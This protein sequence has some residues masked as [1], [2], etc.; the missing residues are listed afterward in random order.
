[1]GIISP[2]VSDVAFAI[3][4]GVAGP[5]NIESIFVGGEVGGAYDFL[6]VYQDAAR[7][8]AAN[9]GDPV[10]SITD[11]S[12]NALHIPQSTAGSRPILRV[13][14]G[15][16]RYLE[17]DGIGAFMSVALALSAYPVTI[18]L[19]AQ[20]NTSPLSSALVA[21][22]GTDTNYHTIIV[23]SAT[24]VI[25]Q[26]RNTSSVGTGGISIATKAVAISQHDGSFVSAWRNGSAI[27]P[28]ANANAFGATTTLYVL[29]LRPA[30]GYAKAFLYPF[31]AIQKALSVSE[32]QAAERWLADRSG[33]TI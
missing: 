33:V 27:T 18:G 12:G 6:E 4:D 25:A 10:G 13:D 28:V 23:S 7:T 3:T 20:D 21:F 29:R 19:A 16:N 11:V 24:N 2:I 31:F 32:R 17:G 8:I 14:A 22:G 1:M 30:G 5:F 15:G 26:T 9:V